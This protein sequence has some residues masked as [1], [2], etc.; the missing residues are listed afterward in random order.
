MILS[1]H[2][3]TTPNRFTIRPFTLVELMVAMTI[4]LI[5]VGM[6]LYIL[7]TGQ[8]NWHYAQNEARMYE[9]SRV[10]F[11]LIEQDLRTMV[12]QDFPQGKEIG[13]FVYSH[14]ATDS[15]KAPV[16]CIVSAQDPE[17]GSK[18]KLCEITWAVHRDPSDPQNAY[19]LRRQVV[20]QQ[21]PD[22]NFMGIPAN[23]FVNNDS[24]S[25]DFETV[26][27]GVYDLTVQFETTSGPVA[28]GSTATERPTQVTVTLSLVDE[29][30]IDNANTELITNSLRTF[31]K[32]IYLKGVHSR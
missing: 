25:P 2:G 14:L 23:W 11:D 17:D 22:W 27:Y 30:V 12:T 3:Q 1:F 10:V 13:F 15:T 24:S 20:S 8:R 29:K 5:M 28:A 19:I 18:S 9:N 32:V 21:S 26:L 16:M 6:M 31:T 7:A 4:L